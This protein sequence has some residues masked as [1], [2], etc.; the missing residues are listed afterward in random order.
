MNDDRLTDSEVALLCDIGSGVPTARAKGAEIETLID[1]GFIER[2]MRESATSLK[3]TAK[4]QTSLAAR[5]A[6]INE[7]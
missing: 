3:L 7:S 6:G 2:D 4:A 1:R 5:G